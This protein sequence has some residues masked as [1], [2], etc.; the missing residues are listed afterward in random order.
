M[1]ASLRDFKPCNET[2]S[3]HYSHC[4]GA[5]EITLVHR[6]IRLFVGD[7]DRG[8]GKMIMI[9]RPYELFRGKSPFEN[10]T[11]CLYWTHDDFALREITR[12]EIWNE[13]EGGRSRKCRILI[14]QPHKGGR[15]ARPWEKEGS[16]QMAKDMEGS[17]S[18]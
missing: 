3:I 8:T 5:S 9:D 17:R 2:V 18:G 16:N 10:F 12:K 6:N 7:W 4:H 1:E 11:S 13:E 14:M 15:A